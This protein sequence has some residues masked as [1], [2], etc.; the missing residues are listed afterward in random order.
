MLRRLWGFFRASLSESDP[1]YHIVWSKPETL[2]SL[3]V[4]GIGIPFSSL[5]LFVSVLLFCF[6]FYVKD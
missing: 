3:P 2:V 6:C 5:S 4:C 1:A